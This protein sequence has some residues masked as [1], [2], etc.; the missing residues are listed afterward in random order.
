[1]TG[2]AL[3]VLENWD[4]TGHFAERQG[5]RGVRDD[6][7][8]LAIAYG[9]CFF[10]RGDRVYFLGRDAIRKKFKN[11]PSAVTQ[12]WIRR[13]DGLVVV[14]GADGKLITTYRNPRFLRTLKRRHD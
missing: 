4:K 5:R 6:A 13:A 12:E 8:M 14:V 2:S 1:M 10:E 9:R 3:S 11:A 7:A